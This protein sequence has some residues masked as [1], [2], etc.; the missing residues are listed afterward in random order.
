[1]TR[2]E[3]IN[4]AYDKIEAKMELNH[5]ARIAREAPVKRRKAILESINNNPNAYRVGGHF[6][7]FAMCFPRVRMM[8]FLKLVE[9]TIL[10][11]IR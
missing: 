7:G 10:K 3:R 2:M 6:E 11:R 1:M 4:A 8:T 9:P 5:Q